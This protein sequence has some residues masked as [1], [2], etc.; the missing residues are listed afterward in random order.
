MM[1]ADQKAELVGA[2]LGKELKTLNLESYQGASS[3]DAVVFLPCGL[4]SPSLPS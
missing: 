4:S 3:R 1:W 2:G